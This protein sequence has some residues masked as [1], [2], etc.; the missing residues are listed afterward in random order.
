MVHMYVYVT[1][2]SSSCIVVSSPDPTLRQEKGLVTLG[3]MLGG[4]DVMR[5]N[6]CVPIRLSMSN[7]YVFEHS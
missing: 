1:V 6:L 4:D 7:Y 5:R 3:S 2:C